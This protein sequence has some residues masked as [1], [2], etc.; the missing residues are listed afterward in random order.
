MLSPQPGLGTT[1]EYSQIIPAVRTGGYTRLTKVPQ[2]Y[3][4]SVTRGLQPLQITAVQ[5][6][7]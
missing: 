2:V 5:L 6:Q 4:A 3:K 1:I 7:V